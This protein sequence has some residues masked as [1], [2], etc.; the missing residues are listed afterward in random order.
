M[1]FYFSDGQPYCVEEK[2]L[3]G[4]SKPY[5]VGEGVK[6]TG[7]VSSRIARLDST[8]PLENRSPE[9]LAKSFTSL[10]PVPDPRRS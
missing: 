6:V 4:G 9:E 8:Q 10:I 2:A 3:L 7:I 1:L 5:T